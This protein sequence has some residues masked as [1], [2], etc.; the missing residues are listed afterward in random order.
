MRLELFGV[1]LREQLDRWL[2]VCVL[3]SA[4]VVLGCAALA[5]LAVLVT[6]AFWE[7]HRLL[8]LGAF[9]LLFLAGAGWCAHRL[10]ALLTG[11]PAPFA[12][13]IAEFRKDAKAVGPSDPS[14][15]TDAR[16]GATGRPTAPEARRARA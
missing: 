15:A 4:A 13:T 8:A 7:G 14:D 12:A 3:A 6:V 16:P 10:S 1:E 11:A 2:R 5:F 9:T